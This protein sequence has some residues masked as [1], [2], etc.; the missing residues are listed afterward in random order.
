[1]LFLFVAKDKPGHLDM[2]LAVRPAHLTW[3]EEA[4]ERLRLAGPI[5]DPAGEK[6]VGSCLVIEAKDLRD[7]TAF[8][9]TDPY[10]QAGLFGDVEIH[11]YRKV[12]G[13]GL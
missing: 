9:A 1:M 4:G 11:P 6:P 13:A 2:R 7:A 8:L 10:A 3:L 5:L 12:T